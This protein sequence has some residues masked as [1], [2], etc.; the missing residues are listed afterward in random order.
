MEI[1]TV[2]STSLPPEQ[3]VLTEEPVSQ[4]PVNIPPDFQVQPK[5]TPDIEVVQDD[6]LGDNVDLMA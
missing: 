1:E 5:E 3:S 2:N 4:E 6:E